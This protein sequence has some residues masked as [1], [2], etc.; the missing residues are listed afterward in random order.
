MK[1]LYFLPVLTAILLLTACG[2]EKDRTDGSSSVIT[3][4]I[5]YPVFIRSPFEDDGGEWWKENIETS[6]RISFIETLFD[7]ACTGKVKTFD[8]LTNEALTAE[9]VC[10]IGNEKDTIRIT[11]TEPP[12]DE[13]DTVIQNHLDLKEIHKVKFLEEWSFDTERHSMSKKL[14]GIAPAL[15]VYDDSSSI[16]GY[17]PLFWIYFDKEYIDKL[18]SKNKN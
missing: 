11:S 14:I 5:E 15:T 10:A 2:P 13:K 3:E 18:S 12:Y 1:T 8:Y 7:W 4:K 17:K 6:K 9:Q 16:K